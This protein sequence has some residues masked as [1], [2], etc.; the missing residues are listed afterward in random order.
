MRAK[1]FSLAAAGVL[2]LLVYFAYPSSKSHPGVIHL[3]VAGAVAVPESAFPVVTTT[4]PPPTTS[5]TLDPRL[6]A[7]PVASRSQAHRSVLPAAKAP[8]VAIQGPPTASSGGMPA[9]LIC[10]HNHEGSYTSQNYPYYGGYQYI[11]STW[12][13]SAT[14]AGYGPGSAQNYANGR[15]DLAPPAVQDAVALHDYNMGYGQIHSNWPQTSRM[16]GV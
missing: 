3:A 2:S 13:T 6:T 11:A 5:T 16:C 9:A 15:A 8:F 12:N 4:T 1:A 10:I 7:P 14:R